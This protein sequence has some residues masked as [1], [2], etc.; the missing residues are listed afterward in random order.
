[1]V[2]AFSHLQKRSSSDQKKGLF[3]LAR[4]FTGCGRGHICH[5]KAGTVCV[6][7]TEYQPKRLVYHTKATSKPTNC[8]V[9]QKYTAIVVTV[10]KP[11]LWIGRFF[12]GASL[13]VALGCAW[14]LFFAA[15]KP[16]DIFVYNAIVLFIFLPVV[17]VLFQPFFI[18]QYPPWAVGLLGEKF[19]HRLINDCRVLVSATRV[20]KAELTKPTSWLQDQRVI[21][22]IIIGGAI[23]LGIWHGAT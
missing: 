2:D 20:S 7:L 9:M 15:E 3:L 10:P 16:E 22:L 13:A 5:D 19:L 6:A 23:I 1:L 11:W 12:F 8:R 14:V 4:C 18:R 17:F 21:W